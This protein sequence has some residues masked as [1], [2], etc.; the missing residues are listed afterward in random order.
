MKKKV[1]SIGLM[2]SLLLFGSNVGAQGL[3]KI[4]SL[5]KRLETI[6]KR[7]SSRYKKDEKEILVYFK[8]GFKMR[9][10]DN[11]FQFQA[12]GRIMHDWG[13]FSE[14]SQFASNIG[15][16]ENGARFRRARFFMAGMLYNTVKFKWDIDV[17]GGTKGVTFKDMYI[18]IPHIP[19]LG[20]FQVGHFKRPASLDSI[21]S[22]KYLTFIERSLTNTFFKTRNTGFAFFNQHFDKRLTWFTFLNQE[23]GERPPDFRTD[24]DW[25]VT[26]RITGL[27][28]ISE[29]G[30]R[31]VHLG[32]SWSYEKATDNSVTFNGARDSEVIGSALLTTGAIVAERYN[33]V[34]LESSVNWNQFSV[35]GEYV[36]TQ[37][38]QGVDTRGELD[39]FYVQGSWYLTGENRHYSRK[40]GAV[41][42]FRPNQN[43]SWNKKW[44]KGHGMGALQLAVRYAELD[45]NDASAGIAGGE[46]E[47]LTVGLNWELNPMSRIMYNYVNADFTSGAGADN[48]TLT[49]NVI[50][51][52]VDF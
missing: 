2:V 47:S 16:Q 40:K 28:Y 36:N 44:S 31:W 35:Q 13:F 52:Q 33:I 14:D 8:N 25:N 26:S 50:R 20:T 30:K 10:R 45:L 39:A 12:G 22:S 3:D 1:F 48:G 18:A 34:G 21:T 29:D 43:F 4:E 32:A 9:T 17:D 5:E 24:G 49:S 38:D 27:P 11:S 46:Q 37:V 19:V 42:R 7:E 41:G 51:F 6:E 23:T 15:N